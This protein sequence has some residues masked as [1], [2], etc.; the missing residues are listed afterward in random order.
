MSKNLVQGFLVAV[1]SVICIQSE[2]SCNF[3]SHHPGNSKREKLGIGVVGLNF[4]ATT[5][6]YRKVIFYA[7]STASASV[8]VMNGWDG[9]DSVP[10]VP[11]DNIGA[12]PNIYFR[13]LEQ[14]KNMFHIITN[15]STGKAL[16]IKRDSGNTFYSWLDYFQGFSGIEYGNQPIR[17]CPND[18]CEQDIVD[19]ICTSA[20]ILA[21]KGD[22][23]QI[24]TNEYCYMTEDKPAP[25]I[26]KGWIKWRNDTV[27]LI[28]GYNNE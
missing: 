19:S 10:L 20:V 14:T 24:E 15:D 12:P 22:W 16:W 13:C 26:V 9:L 21:M 4:G 27:L 25:H 3:K 1:L 6:Y 17:L 7:D 11:F 23:V 2:V 28:G 18:S 8:F 5:S